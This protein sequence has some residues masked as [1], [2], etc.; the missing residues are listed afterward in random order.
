VNKTL[1]TFIKITLVFISGI[2]LAVMFVTAMNAAAND[3]E[4]EP[5][6][7]PATG[8]ELITGQDMTGEISPTGDVDYYQLDG[9]NTLWGY[10]ALLDTSASTASD[11]GTL[12]AYGSDGTTQLQI[13][14]GSWISGSVIAWQHFVNGSAD[15]YL[16]A[17]ETGDD[18]T[19][20]PYT[21][22]YYRIAISEQD[23]VEPNDTWQTANITAKS[24]IA[25]IS[26]TVDVD[27]YSFSVQTGE[28]FLFALN[29]DPDNDGSATDYG[30]TV[31]DPA[32]VQIA[33]ANTG[34]IGDNEVIDNMTLPET[35]VYAYC[36]SSASGTPDPNDE[37][38][39]GPLKNNYNYLPTYIVKPEWLDPSPSGTAA[40][41]ELLTFRLNFTNTTLVAIPGPIKM[42]GNFDDD[43]LTLVDAPGADSTTS[44]KAEWLL[45]ELGAGDLFSATLVTRAKAGC[46]DD[47]HESVVMSYYQLGVG[48]DV[49][50]T[51]EP[52]VYLPLV[53]K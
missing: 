17:S 15:H 40:M 21:L 18:D 45:D 33:A 3:T 32:G 30:L 7:T 44:K 6:D 12:V 4:V 10:V 31:H 50:Y 39:V 47:V 46:V 43:C 41:G 24:M 2:S 35:G 9:V 34:G 27:C 8:T 11:S 16:R 23:E 48:K 29:A 5:N 28:K 38:L 26:D 37:Y 22:R 51:I 49:D 13:D 14:S 42:S 19:I 25:V 53:T 20:T 52:G 1:I 36:V